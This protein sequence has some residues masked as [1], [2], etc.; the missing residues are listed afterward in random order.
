MKCR[1]S[2]TGANIASASA[3]GNVR[4]W[5][6]DNAAATSR[7][8]AICTGV[9]VMSLEWEYKSDRLLLLGTAERRIKAWNVEAKRVVCDLSTEAAFPRVLDLKCSPTDPV[10]CCAAASKTTRVAEGVDGLG[11]GSLTIWNMRTWKT[12]S[13]LP[14]GE[15]PPVMTSVCFNHN[16]KILASGATDGMIRLFDLRGNLPITGWPAHESCVSC[17]RF[18]HDQASI[19]SLGADGKVLEWSLHNQGQILQSQ[20]ASEYCAVSGARLPRHEMAID[21]I[22][23]HVLL[24]SN[25]T[26]SPLYQWEGLR[27]TQR[28]LEHSAAITSVDWHPSLPM[29]LTG[30][31]DHSVRV[32]SVAP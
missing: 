24:T 12:M 23:R 13:V 28:T 2:A 19:F 11:F 5:A 10:F 8:A 25:L 16:G 9:E 31:A 14:L 15:D 7:N 18:S 1:F 3:D 32:T 22:G 26:R 17:V 30:S 20:D 4:I 27:M 21:S 6:L 29:Y